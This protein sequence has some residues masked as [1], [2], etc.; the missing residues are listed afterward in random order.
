MGGVVFAFL[1]VDDLGV[2]GQAAI[3]LIGAALT[4]RGRLVG[5][6]VVGAFCLIEVI[7]VPFYDRDTTT[8]W[9][10][11]VSLWILGVIGL[12]AV[13]GVLR[14]PRRLAAARAA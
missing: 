10:A 11:Q 1:A 12:I 4:L 2:L 14:E 6:I 7:F 9:I 13:V 5:V 8:D 3:F